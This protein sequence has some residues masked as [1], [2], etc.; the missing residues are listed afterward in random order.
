MADAR[1]DT[2]VFW[3]E[4]RDRAILP[5]DGFHLSRSLAKVLRAGPL[6][7]DDAMRD[8]RRGDA[9]PAPSRDPETIRETWISH[10]IEASYRNLH[11]LATPIRSNAGWAMA[12]TWSAAFTAY[13][14]DRVF[15]G[16][17]MFSRA[18]Q[19]QQG[20]A[21]LAGG[22]ACGG[23]ASCCSIASS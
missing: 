4:P 22:A 19:R 11:A 1:E 10:R 21:G 23:R 3:V 6:P 12:T 7:R 8:F 2:E 13:R 17:S 18:R 16:E 14:F 15:C 20:G 5:L 9:M